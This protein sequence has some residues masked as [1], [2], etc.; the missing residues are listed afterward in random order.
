MKW[1]RSLPGVLLWLA[2]TACSDTTLT[3]IYG[4]AAAAGAGEG[5]SSGSSP[6]GTETADGS[7]TGASVDTPLPTQWVVVEPFDYHYPDETAFESIDDRLVI[8]ATRG[9][10]DSA[11]FVYRPPRDYGTV[12]VR[13]SSL[14]SSETGATLP[15][16]TVT[17]SVVVYRERTR[18]NDTIELGWQGG[19]VRGD[20]TQ[21]NR[22]FHDDLRA[23]LPTVPDVLVRDVAAYQIAMAGGEDPP[24]L[25][26]PP[27]TDGARTPAQ[28]GSAVQFWVDIEIPPGFDPGAPRATLIGHLDVEVDDGAFEIPIEVD[29]L[30]T[31]LDALVEHGRH[32]G[33]MRTTDDLDPTFHDVAYAEIVAQHA[34]AMRASIPSARY[35]DM[36][37][38]GFDLILNRVPFDPLDVPEVTSAGLNPIEYH[39]AAS[40]SELADLIRQGEPSGIEIGSEGPLSKLLELPP[41][42][43]PGYYVLDLPVAE[44]NDAADPT[45]LDDLLAYLA[46]LAD[47]VL[48]PPPSAL[49]IH[50]NGFVAHAPHRARIML[51]FWLFESGLHGAMPWGFVA[52]EGRDPHRD[53]AYRGIVYPTIFTDE[54][55]ER[56]GILP[57]YVWRAFREG[58]D[59]LRYALT[60]QRRLGL[61]GTA[62]QQAEFEALMAPYRRLYE[63]GDRVEFRNREADV[64]ATRAGLFEL[65]AELSG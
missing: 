4:G 7:E 26:D 33:V 8:R 6:S 57:S 49:S 10:A 54:A 16:A 60:V 48:A 11:S 23:H 64:R 21:D 44:A 42:Q 3:P 39:G 27:P 50:D 62:A 5:A 15:A 56:P 37:A 29:V 22:G 65:L 24:V 53:A 31:T 30:D 13:P 63:Q 28:A 35:G 20:A 55:G 19:V 61:A 41:D 59:D 17:I 34:N 36:S 18:P 51:G 32:V 46:D 14:V 40:A 47:G 38:L 12:H 58:I 9:E 25:A 52:I 45:V 1:S 2:S 43:S